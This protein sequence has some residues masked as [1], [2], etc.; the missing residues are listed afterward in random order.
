M[1][2]LSQKPAA[3]TLTAQLGAILG[4][5]NKLHVDIATLSESAATDQDHHRLNVWRSRLDS[6]LAKEMKL[7]AEIASAIEHER[8]A[9]LD[10]RWDAYVAACERKH[11]SGDKVDTIIVTLLEVIEEH[12]ADIVESERLLPVRG[13]DYRSELQGSVLSYAFDAA[14]GRL[15]RDVTIRSIGDMSREETAIALKARLPK[16][17]QDGPIGVHEQGG[18]PARE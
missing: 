10:K 3:A 8:L 14:R 6:A 2:I 12:R 7:R 4:D 15:Q 1:G 16:P 18:E 5:I 13:A 11:A 9:G 17:Q